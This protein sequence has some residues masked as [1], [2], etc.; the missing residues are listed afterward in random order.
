MGGTLGKCSVFYTTDARFFNK[1]TLSKV[2]RRKEHS[3]D[4]KPTSSVNN[5]VA[6]EKCELLRFSALEGRIFGWLL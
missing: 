3:R 4:A 5:L 6:F 2:P 1:I